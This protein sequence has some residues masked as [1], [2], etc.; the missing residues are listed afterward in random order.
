MRNL[1]LLIIVVC[2]FVSNTGR[3]QDTLKVMY[4]NLLNF[5]STSQERAD[6]LKKIVQHVLPDMFLVNELDNDFV[7]SFNFNSTS[8]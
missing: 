2:V 8:H 7:N 5:P 3:A 4:Y 1:Q 6:T